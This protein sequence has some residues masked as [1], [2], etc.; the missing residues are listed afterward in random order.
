MLEYQR[1]LGR[2]LNQHFI[3][4]YPGIGTTKQVA[5]GCYLRTLDLHLAESRFVEN[6]AFFSVATRRGTVKEI[7]SRDPRGFAHEHRLRSLSS[8]AACGPY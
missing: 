4:E 5:L 2:A 3:D 8:I 1:L 6:K 7:V